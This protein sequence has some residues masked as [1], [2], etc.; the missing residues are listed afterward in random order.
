MN[1]KIQDNDKQAGERILS[2]PGDPAAYKVRL[3]ADAG[4]V[5]AAQS[6]RYQIFN[7]ELNEGLASAHESGLDVDAFDAVCDHLVVFERAS[8]L[9]VGTYR[10]QTGPTAARHLGYY[11]AREF[12]FAPFEPVRSEVLELGRACV[13]K[14]HRNMAVLGL[15][16]QAIMRYAAEHSNRYFLGCSSVTS[17]DPAL[18]AAMY[19]VLAQR[20]LA[21]PRF[22]TQPL[23][24]MACP[25]DTVAGSPPRPPRLLSA[26]L[27]LGAWICG[28]P[29]IDREFGTIDFLTLLD[30]DALTERS[31]AVLM[32]DS[33]G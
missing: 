14:A 1:T 32:G 23:K 8:G 6:L 31:R 17:Q 25:L 21:E 10:L 4:E 33:L 30:I 22:Q 19:E 11:S 16:W 20:Y 28:P 13:H 3:A 29:A 27:S 7:L 9:T 2:R 26:Y 18:G 15:L 5:R 12:D 24:E